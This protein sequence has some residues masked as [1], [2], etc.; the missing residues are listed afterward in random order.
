MAKNTWYI[1]IYSVISI[2]RMYNKNVEI[3]LKNLLVHIC[4]NKG[5]TKRERQLKMIMTKTF[6]GMCFLCLVSFEFNVE[7]SNLSNMVWDSKHNQ[8]LIQLCH[9]LR[10]PI[11][12][13]NV[14]TNLTKT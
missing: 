13:K 11:E 2:F 4:T 10:V 1:G 6:F 12:M 9:N 8:L 5:K 7:A 3:F 14:A